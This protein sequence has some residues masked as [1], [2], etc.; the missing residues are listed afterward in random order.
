L[1][2]FIWN[3]KAI[4][5][6]WRGV[7][8]AV[9]DEAG[10][11]IWRGEFGPFGE[12]LYERGV[13]S[14]YIPFRLY[15]MYKDMETGLYYNVRRYYDWR[16]GRYLQPDP[17]SELNLY[18]YV[19]NSP[20]DVVDPLGMFE[21]QMQ[22]FGA[23]P[24]GHVGSPNHE[25]ITEKAIESLRN[26]QGYGI[27][28]Q[29]GFRV[30]NWSGGP[31]LYGVIAQCR[32]YEDRVAQGANRAD[33]FYEDDS[34]YH[35][36][37]SNF[38]G[39][40]AKSQIVINP[41]ASGLVEC[42]FDWYYWLN[43]RII[44][45]GW[46]TIRQTVFVPVRAP[47]YESTPLVGRISEKTILYRDDR[48]IITDQTLLGTITKWQYNPSQQYAVAEVEFRT[49]YEK[50]GQLIHPV[51]DFWSHSNAIYVPGCAVGV[52]ISFAFSKGKLV[53]SR[54]ACG[55]YSRRYFWPTIRADLPSEQEAKT[56]GL[57]TGTYGSGIWGALIDKLCTGVG[58]DAHCKLNKD[59]P[60]VN[61]LIF[62]PCDGNIQRD[63]YYE[64]ES[65]AISSTIYHLDK[66]CRNAP[67]LCR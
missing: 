12:P 18:I 34:S 66:F 63:A 15:G 17:V 11:E 9:Y 44:P 24:L 26:N 37:N 56:A 47:R 54:W 38:A 55:V 51:Q 29:H 28:Y 59:A 42:S 50:L 35:C 14:N 67:N 2:S 10:K 41:W 31:W 45:C 1:V 21:T 61:R 23:S 64:A 6:D 53:C 16:V 43:W 40:Y 32:G 65:R 60:G 8:R 30:E 25:K 49:D 19:N 33:C 13:V 52:C 48:P 27:L 3:S 57:K 36:D 62:N 39:C 5:M 7:P 22:L 58:C 46:K 4:A 20:Y